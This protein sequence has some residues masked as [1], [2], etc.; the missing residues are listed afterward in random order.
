MNL[1][2]DESLKREGTLEIVPFANPSGQRG[3]TRPKHP[4]YSAKCAINWK[5][6]C[7]AMV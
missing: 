7:S 5:G 2:K 6:P 3:I 1:V 4:T